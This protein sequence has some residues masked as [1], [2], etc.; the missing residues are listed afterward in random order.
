MLLFKLSIMIKKSAVFCLVAIAVTAT[1]CIINKMAMN[2]V[3][4]ALTTEDSAGVFTGDSDPRLVED[5]LPFTIKMYESLLAA[6]PT[7]QGLL[8]TTGSLFIMYAN[9]FVQKPAEELPQ[10]RYTERQ[11]ALGR[12]KKLY[13][14]GLD[15]LYQGLERKYPGFDGAYQRGTLPKILKKMK[16][17]DVP[18]L[19]WAA[20]GGTAAF[21]LTPLDLDLGMRIPEFLA[22]AMRAYELD[23]GFNAGALD[24]FLL[25]YY[26]SVPVYMGGDRDKAE[27]HYRRALEKSGGRLASP[28]VS[29]A[30]AVSI[31]A[32]DYDTFKICLETALVIDLDADPA[33]RLVN[34]ITQRK[35][36]YLLDNAAL[37]FMDAGSDDDWDWDD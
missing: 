13:L 31:P 10:I 36:R 15:L 9:G 19:Y 35:A 12:A 29:Y 2:A 33:N 30:Q 11:A 4:N 8:R 24:D 20:A 26:A 23:S 7:H 6:N 18:S 14:R 25:I 32:Q 3:S 27:L 17:S 16:K 5:A 34:T 28:Y 22:L 21:A 1:S 37:F